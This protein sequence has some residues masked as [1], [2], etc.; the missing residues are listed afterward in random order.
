VSI[1]GFYLPFAF[2]ALDMIMG[3]SLMTAA[4]G[5]AV[6]HLWYFLTTL[7]PRGSGQEYLKTP[8]LVKRAAVALGLSA[9]P[10]RAPDQAA[11]ASGFRAFQGT[12]RNLND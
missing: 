8:A 10:R 7:L 9:P 6:G 11:T 3:K 5:I 2:A 12:A 4:F 1:K